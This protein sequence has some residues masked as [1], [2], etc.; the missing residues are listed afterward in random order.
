MPARAAFATGRHV[1]DIGYWDNAIGYD[2]AVPGWGHALQGAGVTVESVGKLHYQ[3]DEAPAGFDAEH[4]PMNL[5]NGHGMVWGSVRDP[6]PSQ[7]PHG[8]RM[9]GPYIGPGE[10]T[11]TRYDG[12]VTAAAQRWLQTHANDGQPWCLFVGLVAPHFPLVVPQPYLDHYSIAHLKPR[13]LHP[14]TGYQRHPWIQREHDFLPSEEQF[15]ERRA[16]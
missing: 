11:Y 8:K 16:I 7:A 6:P 1:H 5:Y 15:A 9:L 12:S 3:N 13:K 4:L 14:E 2:G 10:S